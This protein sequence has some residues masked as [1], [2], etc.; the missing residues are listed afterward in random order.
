MP[1]GLRRHCATQSENETARH[2]EDVPRNQC[3]AT[4]APRGTSPGDDAHP[5][6]KGPAMA[7]REQIEANRKNAQKST[8]PRDTDRTRFNGLKHG[9][10]AEQHRPAR[11]GPRRLPGRGRG[12]VRRL[13][14]HVPH[15]RR[16]DRAAPPS[17]PGGSSA[18]PP[19]SRPTAPSSPT[20]P[21]RA[22]DDEVA[23]RVER[24]VARF[25]RRAEGGP[26]AAGVA[27]RRARPPARLLGRLVEALE[28]GPGRLGP[29]ALPRP[30]DAP[31]GPPRP[32]PCRWRPGRCPAP[33]PGCCRPTSPAPAARS[34]R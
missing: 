26:V 7:T 28:G 5:R 25:E 12:L 14:A 10:R 27:R 16:A 33:R 32:T 3:G 21:G 23:A 29:A 1:P 24:A 30:A 4:S 11:R 8:G 34:C 20:T 15:P 13:E 6:G 9:L 17:P 2:Y 19:P 31:A 18:P 22:F